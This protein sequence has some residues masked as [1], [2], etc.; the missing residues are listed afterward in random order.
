MRT[1]ES[2]RGHVLVV[3]LSYMII[4]EIDKAWSHLY[5][6]VEEGL[7]SLSTLTL[8]D[9]KFGDDKAFQQIPEPREQNKLMLDALNIKIPKFSP[10]NHVNVVT[11]TSRRKSVIRK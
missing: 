7:R 8:M 1:E 3:M 9:V 2:T 10:K 11:R 4:R 5:L 6:T